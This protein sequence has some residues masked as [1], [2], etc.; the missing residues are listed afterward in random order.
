MAAPSAAKEPAGPAHLLLPSAHLLGSYASSLNQ[1]DRTIS[2]DGNIA[3]TLHRHHSV[4]AVSARPLASRQHQVQQA[5]DYF[6]AHRLWCC[7]RL[8]L[9]GCARHCN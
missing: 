8:H 2:S 5:W 3:R 6:S 9:L 7:S 1:P 4:F